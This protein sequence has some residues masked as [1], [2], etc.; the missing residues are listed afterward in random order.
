V[1]CSYGEDE[2]SF[3]ATL[4]VTDEGNGPGDTECVLSDVDEVDITIS[5]DTSTDTN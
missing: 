4:T 1:I 3:T 2:A 5:S